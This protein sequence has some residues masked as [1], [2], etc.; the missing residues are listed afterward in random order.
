MRNKIIIIAG[1]II[2][3]AGI[4][5]ASYFF[6]FDNKVDEA[7]NA[8]EIVVKKEETGFANPYLEQ[9]IVDYLLTQERFAWQTQEG[10]S[11]FCVI[12]NLYP[13][14]EL[15][16]LYVWARCSEFALESDEL[17]DLS[18]MSAPIKIDYPNELSYYDLN[19]FSYLSPVDGDGYAESVRSIFPEIVQERIFAFDNDKMQAINKKL[20]QVAQQGLV[21]E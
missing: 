5:L 6:G 20:E 14:T 1:V 18:G 11:N 2:V 21:R 17:K 12:E 19:K 9:A 15:F 3:L 4:S 7:V 10:S 16:P 13:E 8:P